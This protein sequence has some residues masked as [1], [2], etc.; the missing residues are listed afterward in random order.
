MKNATFGAAG[1]V[2]FLGG[3]PAFAQMP[4]LFLVPANALPSTNP[5]GRLQ[6]TAQPGDSVCLDLCISSPPPGLHKAMGLRIGDAV[7]G[8]MGT[9]TINCASVAIDPL[10]PTHPGNTLNT[11]SLGNCVGA[12]PNSASC[13]LSNLNGSNIMLAATGNYVGQACWTVSANACGTF[14]L[15]YIGNTCSTGGTA[16]C[17]QTKIFGPGVST[18]VEVTDDGA[19]INVESAATDTCVNATPIGDGI[20]V[21][22]TACAGTDGPSASCGPIQ[23]DVWFEYT[24]PC[25]GEVLVSTNAGRDAVYA[26]NEGCPAATEVQCDGT[27]SVGPFAGDQYLIRV[28]SS[29]GSPVSGSLSV[30][31]TM[32][33]EDL[34][35]GDPVHIQQCGPPSRP[36]QCE[37]WWCDPFQGCVSVPDPDPTPCDDGLFCTTVD[38]CAGDGTCAGGP[39]CDDDDTCTQDAC[40]DESCTNLPRTF[41]D[42]NHDGMVDIFDIL[43]VLDGFA[44]VFVSPCTL[45]NMDFAGCPGGDG[46]IDIFDILAVLDGF[47]GIN[48][49][50]CPGGQ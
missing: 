13:N 6:V 38:T 22:N 5:S 37:L 10:A 32:L 42:A 14:T 47:A 39:P 9:V 1:W 19:D 35:P 26:A 50:G 48:L 24:A 4:R 16:G 43:C 28:G 40:A 18:A 45:S 3:I 36:S 27:G 25:Y 34:P 31:C 30:E 49:C 15:D 21:F 12:P 44:G 41:G 33:C 8:K 11:V 7:G 23:N 20:H 29:D 17:G 46:V 2:V